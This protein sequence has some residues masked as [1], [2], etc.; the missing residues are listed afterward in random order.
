MISNA[1]ETIDASAVAFTLELC[2]AIERYTASRQAR[3][4]NAFHYAGADLRHAVER[5]LYFALVNDDSLY[6]YF[7]SNGSSANAYR[8][9][10]LAGRIA[11]YLSVSRNIW[12]WNGLARRLVEYLP[13]RPSFSRRAA[14]DD[15][16]GNADPPSSRANV[17]FFAPQ[18][19][20]VRF[21]APIARSCETSSAFLCLDDAVSAAA[22]AA[23]F[24]TV[25]VRRREPET[26]H[27]L[28]RSLAPFSGL[29]LDYDAVLSAL[30]HAAPRCVAIPEGNTPNAEVLNRAARRLGIPT[31]CVQQGW[32]PIVHSGFRHMTFSSMCVWGEGF[33]E[34]LRP[35]NPEQ[36]FVVTGDPGID[37]CDVPG[38]AIGFFLQKG[39][40]LIT[41]SA[42][43][44]MLRLII[45]SATDFPHR[46]IR[47]RE[48]PG[49]PLSPGERAY[50]S[51]HDNIRLMPP[52]RCTL[53]A[54]LRGCAVIVAVFST[55]IV[56][57]IAYRA[58]PLI[59]NVT[60]L[61]RYSPDIAGAGAGI[62]VKGFDDARRALR[63]LLSADGRRTCENA[64]DA[65]RPR[66]L[67]TLGEEAVSAIGEEIAR[68]SYG[69]RHQC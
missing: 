1:A 17:L 50:L 13:A 16:R 48:H 37:G 59:V 4:A 21:L 65:L 44:Q 31:L 34:L 20:F 51:G 3:R 25:E 45:D 53:D 54:T 63:N 26:R 67:A 8:L 60:G 5:V 28:P 9:S 33:A 61:E 57:A 69:A 6:R 58:V 15:S 36:P 40:R 18:P 35:Y 27:R 29:A 7:V 62:E 14:G 47:V 30:M 41:E 52:D 23:G 10:P 42:W 66:Y 43:R 56:E 2:A 55:T 49:A 12:R 68:L 32:S 38:E 64:L 11:P 19:K 24:A 22:T 39:S 46:E